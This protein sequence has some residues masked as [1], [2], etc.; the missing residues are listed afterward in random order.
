[1]VNQ[2]S[3]PGSF[4]LFQQNQVLTPVAIHPEKASGGKLKFNVKLDKEIEFLGVKGVMDN[5][6]EV[7]YPVIEIAS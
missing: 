7:A 2:V 5:N 4:F 6:R 1:V 3:C